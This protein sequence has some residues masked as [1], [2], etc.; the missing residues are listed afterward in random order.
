MKGKSHPGQLDLFAWA[1]SQPSN[2]IDAREAL[3]RKAALQVMYPPPRLINGGKVIPIER[4]AAETH[5]RKRPISRF[6]GLYQTPAFP[7]VASR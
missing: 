3:W 5:Q 4:T 7:P 2:V 1:D 6:F